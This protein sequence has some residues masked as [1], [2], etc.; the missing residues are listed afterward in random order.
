M[1]GRQ[2]DRQADIKKTKGKRT[3]RE[4]KEKRE[5][6]AEIRLFEIMSAR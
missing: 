6:K 3:E 5:R 1:G 2:T 4:R